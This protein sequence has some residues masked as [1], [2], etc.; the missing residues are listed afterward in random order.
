VAAAYGHSRTPVPA[1]QIALLSGTSEAYGVLFKL[2]CSPG[3]EVLV[4]V[5]SYP[6]LELLGGLEAVAVRSYA[7]ERIDTWRIDRPDLERA[8]TT[9]TRAVLVVSPNNP[10]GAMTR[11]ADRA[12]IGAI[13][14]E[15]GLA[16]IA[17]EVFGEYRL[18]AAPDAVS[19]Y[20]YREA[21][22]FTLGGLSKL[23]ALPQMKVAW[24]AASGPDRLVRDA[25]SRIEII[26]D[27]YLSVSTPTQ[28]ALPA[29]LE[30]GAGLRAAILTRIGR[31]LQ[32]LR[33]AL[34]SAA[35]CTLYEPEG[36]WSAVVRVPGL[37][38]EDELVL[39]LLDEADTLVQPG[40]FFDFDSGTHVVIS[41]LP[42]AEVFDAGIR[43]VLAAVAS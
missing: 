24:I 39:R 43:R 34:A 36:G 41:L 12:W 14:A 30:A 11:D 26:C 25:L 38:A 2:L 42:P 13:A 33:L 18:A 28:L 40:Y 9:R 17:D 10:T 8:I 6:L 35:S 27:A 15:R 31:N 29:L 1:S 21:L 3:D 32:A 20:G 37:E 19:Y 5:P 4:P 23:A 16:V 22:T 7:T